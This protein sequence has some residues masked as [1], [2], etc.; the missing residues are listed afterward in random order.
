MKSY[1][2][3][4]GTAFSFTKATPPQ[5]VKPLS[6]GGLAATKAKVISHPSAAPRPD[7]VKLAT[8]MNCDT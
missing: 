3:Y 6:A 4:F 2:V 8:D 5:M 7:V 1:D